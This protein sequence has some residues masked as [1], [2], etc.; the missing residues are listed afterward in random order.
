MIAEWSNEIFHSKFKNCLR[1][2]DVT[3]SLFGGR[4]EV[5]GHR[6]IGEQLLVVVRPEVLVS[7][8]HQLVVDDRLPDRALWKMECIQLPKPTI[9]PK[10]KYV[11]PREASEK[12]MKP[13]SNADLKEPL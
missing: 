9:Q 1:H 10:F 13:I 4:G 6:A 5:L 8:A 3:A 12:P 11:S 2:F 7:R